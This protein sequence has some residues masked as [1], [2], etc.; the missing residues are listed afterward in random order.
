MVALLHNCLEYTILQPSSIFLR[1]K[2]LRLFRLVDRSIWIPIT[3]LFLNLQLNMS[4][5]LVY[6]TSFP[7]LLST[8]SKRFISTPFKYLEQKVIASFPIYPSAI[9][10]SG[11]ARFQTYSLSV[12]MTLSKGYIHCICTGSSSI[13]SSG[14]CITKWI[15]ISKNIGRNINFSLLRTNTTC[16]SACS[17]SSTLS[18]LEQICWKK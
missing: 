12:F 16:Y 2:K 3:T 5:F 9:K 6:Y 13:A 10:S 4:S 18:V 7:H 8:W 11:L 15:M 14:R 1:V 17:I